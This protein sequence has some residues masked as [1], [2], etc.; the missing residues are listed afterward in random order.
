[1]TMTFDEIRAL[2]DAHIAHT[3]QKLPIAI[4]RGKGTRIWDV[5]G[6]EYIDYMGGYGV[7]ILGQSYPKVINA[8]KEQIDRLM[9]LH[10]SLYNEQRA[11]FVKKLVSVSPSGLDMVYL[12]N[13]GAEALE[14]ALKI[15]VKYSKRKKILAMKG[16]YH[17]KTLGAL[18]LTYGEKYRTSFDE[19]VYKGVEFAEF[20]NLDD[21]ERERNLDEFAAIFVEPV[22]GE[23]GI[24]IPPEGFFKGLREI[25]DKH[26]SLLVVDEVQSGLGRT[27][28][29]WAHQHWGIIP[30]IM[31]IGKG[32]GGGIPMAATIGKTEY[33]STLEVGEHTSTMGGNPIACA[34]GRAV[35]ESLYD[36]GVVDKARI[37]GEYL[38]KELREQVGSSKIVREL[39]GKGLMIALELKVRFHDILF[40]AIESGLITLYSGKTILRLLPPLII[41][42]EDITKG[43]SILRESLNWYENQHI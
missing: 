37:S 3:Y 36:D 4:A 25:A 8:I 38:Q 24:K 39:R 2:E 29:M 35:L 16:A 13:S 12:S 23:G 18:S 32:I 43:T 14:A 22:Q 21:V 30:D 6:K 27:G 5:N 10:S 42:Q 26:G 28:K 41:D 1:M 7:A 20:G 34:A 33:L 19:F 9:I 31:T 40:K 17:G 11:L 15:A